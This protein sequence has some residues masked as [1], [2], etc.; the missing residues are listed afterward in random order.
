KREIYIQE[1]SKIM[2]ISEDV[3]Y[4]TLAQSSK[5][6]IQDA[7]KQF[8]QD[9]EAFKVIKN[10]QAQKRVDV[11]YELERKIIQ[12]LLL[13]GNRTE[14]FEDLILKENEK[15]ELILEPIVQQAKEFEK[16]FLD[17]QED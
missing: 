15:N 10:E 7:N 9:Q 12:I 1:C 6:D 11:Q 17:L 8:R 3:L 14:D 2:D 13:Y 4:S 5:K 16:I